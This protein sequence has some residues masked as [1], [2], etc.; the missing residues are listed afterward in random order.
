MLTTPHQPRFGLSSRGRSPSISQLALF[1]TLSVNLLQAGCATTSSVAQPEPMK[2]PNP[3]RAPRTVVRTASHSEWSAPPNKER[4]TDTEDDHFDPLTQL[5]VE[6]EQRNPSI[7]RLR[8]QYWAAL[9]K[10][11]HIDRLPD[12]K[13]GA[14][15]FAHP[16][17]TAAGSQR[18]NLTL[19]QMLP[20]LSRLDA[21]SRQACFEAMALRQEYLSTR[22]K[23][24]ASIRSL[25]Y[26]LYVIEKQIQISRANQSFL[27]SL[28]D[29]AN[30]RVLARDASQGDVLSGTL[31][32]G[33]L[34]EQL[35]QLQQRQASTKA[36]INRLVGRASDTPISSSQTPVAK[37]PDW[38]HAMLRELAIANQPDIEAARI[39]T[40]A[41]RWG[42]EI[43]RLKRKPDFTVSASWF[44]IDD[45]RPPSNLVD[46]GKDAWSMGAMMSVPLWHAKYDAMEQEARWKHAA[47][48]SNV[49][50]VIQQY[51][52]LL[53]EQWEQARAADATAQLYEKTIIPDAQRTLTADQES[54]AQGGVEFDRVVRDFQ[55]LLTLQMGFHRAIGD[56]ATA[57]AR[58][59]QATATELSDSSAPEEDSYK[60]IDSHHEEPPEPEERDEFFAE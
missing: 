17:E 26:R 27:Q 53:L 15:V 10:A 11:R 56:L 3:E 31:E 44:A 2:A 39:R 20:W 1:V 12:P 21:Q 32:Y 50:E 6:A 5:E 28:I 37:L 29:V 30:S 35:V 51:D 58:I 42:I 55:N 4:T 33:K 43:A 38:N 49:D 22:L 14:N 18:A 45:N 8:Q 36:Q 59:K 19:S 57:I 34:E 52:A 48:H 60:K 41:S 23:I 54:Y 47:S 9:A 7:R 46:I 16:I 24:I 25:W 40:Q 13:F